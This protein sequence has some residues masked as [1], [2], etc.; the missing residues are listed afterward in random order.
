MHYADF[1]N[2]SLD[3]TNSRLKLPTGTAFLKVV[4]PP[5]HKKKYSVEYSLILPYVRFG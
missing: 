2:F 4:P 5:H 3:E 1:A